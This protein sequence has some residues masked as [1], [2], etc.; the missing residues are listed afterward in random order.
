M[1][2]F[3]RIDWD[4]VAGVIAAVV[5]LVLHLLHVVEEDVL[6]AIVLVILAIMLFQ[7]TRRDLRDEDSQAR[8][9]A[10]ELT[11]KAIQE[12]V[13]RPEI[14][15]V[16]PEALR[17]ESVRFAR[18]AKGRMGWFNVCLLMFEPQSLFDSLLRP[19]IENPD[20]SEIQFTLDR[21]EHDR[22]E[23]AV[24]PKVRACAEGQKVREP[25]WSRIEEGISFITRETADP[26][27]VEAQVSFWGEPFM[28]TTPGS[29]IPRY[30]LHVYSHSTLISRLLDIERQHRLTRES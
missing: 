14:R 1:K 22:W 3:R 9:A 8:I 24:M 29:G 21:S 28:A 13:G 16:G 7:N 26:G 5:A 4:A 6:L 19:A 30:I 17:Q 11:S 18:D 10:I 12:S 15:M 2:R 20:V 27:E 23:T 25:V